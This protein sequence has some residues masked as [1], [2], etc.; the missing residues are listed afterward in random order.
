MDSGGLMPFPAYLA[1]DVVA[2]P[3]PGDAITNLAGMHADPTAN[4]VTVQM[5]RT[6][7][8]G[9]LGE[10]ITGDTVKTPD[11]KIN[12]NSNSV[13]SEDMTLTTAA[14]VRAGSEII[15]AFQLVR[16]KRWNSLHGFDPL[17][18]H[19]YPVG[20]YVMTSPGYND[21][22]T[23]DYQSL[24]GYGKN[25]L[26]QNDI[27]STM[28]WPAGT[29]VGDIVAAVF[30]AAGLLVLPATLDTIV[31]FPGDWPAKALASPATYTLD[32]TDIQF[33]QIVNDVLKQ[34]GCRPLYVNS[35]GRW[36][37]AYL[38]DLTSEANRWEWFGSSGTGIS[39]SDLESRIVEMH[40]PNYSGDVWA[41][42]NAWTYIVSGATSTPVLGNGRYE[43]INDRIQPA[44]TTSTGRVLRAIRSVSATSQS[45]LVAQ[46]NAEINAELSAIE[47]I[48][49]QTATWPVA[50]HFDV[51]TF[52]HKSLPL[53]S[54]RKVQ[55]QTWSLS[56]WG[57]S[58]QWKTNV[59]VKLV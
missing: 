29:A 20:H 54:Y 46:A 16:N 47:Q 7:L 40:T 41:K 38:T 12:Y 28:Q 30:V 18:F 10:D 8:S 57:D 39:S 49:F 33:I 37:I 9:V 27:A 26:L 53:Q 56:L 36:Q 31:D 25:Y 3:D 23:A 59:A 4:D 15:A 50:G 52:H 5:F 2:D 17:T 22:D 48:S 13:V 32:G 58:M 35:I 43:V 45:D 55:A 11:C 44:D 21:L 51:F 19:R 6:D 42:P 1:P 14:S 34:S 24:R